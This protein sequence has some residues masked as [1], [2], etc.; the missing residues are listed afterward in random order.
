MDVFWVLSLTLA[1][2]SSVADVLATCHSYLIASITKTWY[3]II[4]IYWLLFSLI[5]IILKQ[6]LTAISFIIALNFSFN[7]MIKLHS[8]LGE[9]VCLPFLYLIT[10]WVIPSIV[11]SSNKIKAICIYSCRC[12]FHFQPVCYLDVLVLVQQSLFYSLWL[13]QC[14]GFGFSMRIMLVTHSF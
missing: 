13:V 9:C 14:C 8:S 1:W 5:N 7:M 12:L 4:L 2:A 10:W 11:E 3:F 6:N